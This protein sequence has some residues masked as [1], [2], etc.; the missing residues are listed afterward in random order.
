[1][2]ETVVVPW[3]LGLHEHVAVIGL[4]PEVVRDLQVVMTRPRSRKRTVP[5]TEV[6]A[7]MLWVVPFFGAE[8]KERLMVEMPVEMVTVID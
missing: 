5:A 6:V 4:V 7:V 2:A 1:M 3:P 8:A